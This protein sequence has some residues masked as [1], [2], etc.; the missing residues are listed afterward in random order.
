M[1][2]DRLTAPSPRAREPLRYRPGSARCAQRGVALAMVVWFLAAMSLLVSGIVSQARVDTRMAQMHVARAKA[3]AAG[4]GA[5]Q[6]MLADMVAGNIEASPD[7]PLLTSTYTLGDREV[8]VEMVPISGLIDPRSASPKVLLELFRQQGGMEEG[9]AQLL[10]DN[11]LK[12]RNGPARG[13]R[14]LRAVGLYALEDIL[15]VEGI[16]RTMLDATRDVL[17]V[18]A[19]ARPTRGFSSELGGSPPAVLEILAAAGPGRAKFQRGGGTRGAKARS[20]TGGDFRIDARVKNDKQIIL[21]RRW[22]SLGGGVTD[23]LPWKFSRTEPVRVIE[24]G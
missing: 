23:G 9:D 3:V 22:V 19:G 1:A 5:I 8:S 12:L 13:V 2:M 14:Q 21:R 24:A 18:K 10:A 11:V 15:R 7:N 17:V 16:G 4:D 20:V 6:L